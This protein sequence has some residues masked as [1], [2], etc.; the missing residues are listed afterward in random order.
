MNFHPHISLEAGPILR[1]RHEA[2][3]PRSVQQFSD[4]SSAHQLSPP[5]GSDQVIDWVEVEARK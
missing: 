1:G 4:L 5:N 2:V 3:C